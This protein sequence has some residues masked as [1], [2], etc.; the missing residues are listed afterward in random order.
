MASRKPPRVPQ[1]FVV[2][3]V[4]VPDANSTSDTV[5]VPVVMP[6]SATVLDLKNK[7]IGDYRIAGL[8]CHWVLEVTKSSGPEASTP[9]RITP[10]GVYVARYIGEETV[11]VEIEGR[12]A[13]STA[14]ELPRFKEGFRVFLPRG[15]KRVLVVDTNI[16]HDWFLDHCA[17]RGLPLPDLPADT[18][19]VFND[20]V[21]REVAVQFDRK[22]PWPS[23]NEMKTG[24]AHF[25]PLPG[26]DA[27]RYEQLWERWYPQVL[28]GRECRPVY[29]G[30]GV[31][32][33]RKFP[34]TLAEHLRSDSDR[35]DFFI[36]ADALLLAHYLRAQ[37][38]ERPVQVILVTCD[39]AFYRLITKYASAES[40]H[41]VLGAFVSEADQSFLEKMLVESTA[42]RNK[43]TSKYPVLVGSATVF[44][45][46]NFVTTTELRECNPGE[47][48]D[49]FLGVDPGISVA[50]APHR[51]SVASRGVIQRT[52][53]KLM[54]HV[55]MLRNCKQTQAL[56]HVFD[57][58]P[59]QRR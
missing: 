30:G 21:H 18:Y 54:T 14:E 24:G 16:L 56:V 33:P 42:P 49:V 6:R 38:A 48:L 11:T 20:Q 37:T 15:T 12:S 45:D 31:Y 51:E 52:S 5:V 55:T 4:L 59:P 10:D 58:L 35:N 23:L 8:P 26:S 47:Q 13:H 46:G 44:I 50:F 27:R 39:K 29:V 43:N 22:V 57:Q 53:T 36:Y 7:L 19:M 3:T 32:T 2:V 25:L 41:I 40:A 17:P 9:T 1:D 28:A 34:P